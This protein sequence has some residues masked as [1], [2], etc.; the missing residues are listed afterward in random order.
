MRRP[1]SRADMNRLQGI[2]MVLG[3]QVLTYP[4]RARCIT[5]PVHRERSHTTMFLGVSGSQRFRY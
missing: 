2:M 3:V 4:H 1:T 5:Q